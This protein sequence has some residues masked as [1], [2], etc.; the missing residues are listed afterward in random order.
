MNYAIPVVIELQ[1]LS[2]VFNLGTS[3]GERG[4]PKLSDSPKTCSYKNER[5]GMPEVP[6]L[7]HFLSIP[8]G[9]D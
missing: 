6:Q 5:N 9:L 2:S 1:Y 7:S 8:R 3:R 4:D